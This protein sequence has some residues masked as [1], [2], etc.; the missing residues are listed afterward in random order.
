M[1]I[2][3]VNWT[4]LAEI[5]ELVEYCEEDFSGFQK[6]IEEYIQ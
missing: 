4:K 1:L 6:K 2:M 3:T 5:Q